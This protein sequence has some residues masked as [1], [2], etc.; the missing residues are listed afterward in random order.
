M[1]KLICNGYFVMSERHSGYHL[2]RLAGQNEER[3]VNETRSGNMQRGKIENFLLAAGSEIMKHVAACLIN[4]SVTELQNATD[5]SDT[6]TRLRVRQPARHTRRKAGDG[7]RKGG[8]CPET[9]ITSFPPHT[10]F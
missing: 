5:R 8:I 1:L 10:P 3:L 6:G 7:E 2:I 9:N 4:I